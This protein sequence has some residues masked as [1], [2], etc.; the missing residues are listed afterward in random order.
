MK[1]EPDLAQ[2]L[3]KATS[4]EDKEMA[5]DAMRK[6]ETYYMGFLSDANKKIFG[7]DNDPLGIR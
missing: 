1:N 3:N 2:T 6:Q 5:L 4:P 7:N